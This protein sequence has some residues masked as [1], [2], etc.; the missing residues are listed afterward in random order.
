MSNRRRHRAGRQAL[1][2]P[3]V[4]SRRLNDLRTPLSLQLQLQ[5]KP[6]GGLSH[7]GGSPAPW[8]ARFQ[9]GSG[10]NKPPRGPLAA[11]IEPSDQSVSNQN[12][13]GVVAMLALSAW[14]KGL[15]AIVEA[16]QFERARAIPDQGVERCQE[17][18]C[19]VGPDLASSCAPAL[20]GEPG[21]WRSTH[22]LKQDLLDRSGAGH[23][24][25]PSACVRR[26]HRVQVSRQFPRRPRS[27]PLECLGAGPLHMQL[28]VTW[29]GHSSV[30]AAGNV[31]DLLEAAPRVNGDLSRPPQ[32]LECR[33]V[34][35]PLPPATPRLASRAHPVVNVANAH[36]T[37]LPEQ[38]HRLLHPLRPIAA[39]SLPHP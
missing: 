21:P 27:K 35:R 37:G 8:V 14:N 18:R 9:P 15:E 39:E 24:L 30:D 2:V 10:D 11:E 13:H 3:S 6:I 4:T 23:S 25:A 33:L 7:R 28:C 19:A 26:R 29:T 36:R 12:R 34:R 31:V 38:I 20:P 32:V 22:P 17:P 5:G 16:E 1:G